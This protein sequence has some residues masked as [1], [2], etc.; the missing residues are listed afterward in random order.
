[1]KRVIYRN[2]A[3]TSLL[4][5]GWQLLLTPAGSFENP[6]AIADRDTS[7]PAK[8]PGT[9]A[10][11]LSEAGHFDLAQPMPLHNQDAWYF[12]TLQTAHAG[13][14][15]L[16]FEGLTCFAQV[17]LN[18]KPIHDVQS[19]FVETS[20][21]LIL[22]G[23]DEIA[24]C[25]RALE[26]HLNSPRKRARWRSAM[27]S[28]QGLRYLRTT[29]LGYMPGWCPEVHAIGPYRAITLVTEPE[30]MAE[31]LVIHSIL[32]RDGSGTLKLSG[33]FASTTSTAKLCC[34]GQ[35]TTI[36]I[37]SDSTGHAEL[38]MNN[39]DPWWPNSHGQPNLYSV[40]LE[41]DG[42]HHQLG[43]TGFRRI[44]ERRDTNDNGFGLTINDEPIFCRGAVWS[45]ADLIS[46]SPSK[47]TYEP[48]LRRAAEAGM[49]MLR[50]AGTG[51]YEGPAFFELCDELGIMVWQDL[52]LANFDYPAHDES[53]MEQLSLEVE[54]LLNRHSHNPSLVV[55]CGG[56]EM[57]QQA[58][59]F[60]L[61]TERRSMPELEELL[62]DRVKAAGSQLITVKNSP[63]GGALP[64]FPN[65]GVAHYF[66]V[67]AY[68]QPISDA[69][70]ANVSFASECLALSHIPE[71]EALPTRDINSEAWLS[72]VP[73]DRGA[74]WNFEDI[75]DHYL[76]Q[77]YDRDPKHLRSESIEDYLRLSR[78]TS[79][80]LVTELYSEFRRHGSSCNGALMLML[81]DLYP[82][83]GWGLL[84]SKGL[85]KSAYFAAKRMFQPIGISLTDEATN[86]LDIHLW[87]ETAEPKSCRLELSCLKDG[88]VKVL[89]ANKD[90]LMSP[91]SS[92]QINA[93]EIIGAFFDVNYTYRFGPASHEITHVQLIDHG[94]N[95]RLGEGFHFP[96]GR[97]AA[98]FD[99]RLAVE[100]VDDA[101]INLSTSGFV[102]SVHIDCPGFIP[103]DNYFHISAGEQKRI[104][105]TP[106][107][108]G[109]ALLSGSVTHLG[110]HHAVTF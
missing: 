22:T 38:Q 82:S 5:E 101:H 54:Q 42:M 103:S 41:I 74:D 27:M 98:L 64:F 89:V 47:E 40:S 16:S 33:K 32:N 53:F 84:D 93:C 66:G 92:M 107:M 90:L 49:N 17:F 57:H 13:K 79:A 95:E 14:A 20:A 77:L 45:N 11:A 75:R 23:K 88:A 97:T 70:R 80:E 87:N 6:P 36:R 28:N 110:S 19:M 63:S 83:C 73:H 12:T 46:L 99:N 37:D 31:V 15:K 68:R 108:D 71:D 72:L 3:A 26:P 8:V 85:P 52:M 58:A 35:Q 60:G 55:L 105:F 34:A 51:T 102:Q 1:M 81:Q 78:A 61:P 62:Q 10:K 106:L 96:L 24:I 18:G 56:S 65:N 104:G 100:R 94:S 69:R 25:F 9:V 91:R 30:P 109:R 2:E 29:A 39:I 48:I 21:D 7:I 44:E 50:I 43:K 4:N 67:G 59:M 76:Q 86:G